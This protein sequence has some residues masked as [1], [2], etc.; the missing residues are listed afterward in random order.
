[1]MKMEKNIE[2]FKRFTK[3]GMGSWAVGWNPVAQRLVH[4]AMMK[5]VDFGGSSVLDLGGGD[6]EL[7]F[8]CVLDGQTPRKYT[9]IDLMPELCSVGCERFSKLESVDIK[10]IPGEMLSAIRAFKDGCYDFVVAAGALDIVETNS[11]EHWQFM[12][13]VITEMYRVASRAIVLAVQSAGAKEK[14]DCEFYSD[15]A[16]FI[17]EMIERFGFNVVL[18]HSFAPHYMVVVVYKREYPWRELNATQYN[19]PEKRGG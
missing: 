9:C 7:L 15:P 5:H 6:G 8:N 4:R 17:R 19:A 14:K 10:F 1:M 2:F 18:D 13:N 12:R 3:Y 16:W 11:V